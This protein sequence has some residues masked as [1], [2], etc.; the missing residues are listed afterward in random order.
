MPRARTGLARPNGSQFRTR[1]RRWAGRATLNVAAG[2]RG[3]RRG[4]AS[5]D[6]DLYALTLGPRPSLRRG[7]QPRVNRRCV[8]KWEGSPALPRPTPPHQQHHLPRPSGWVPA[9]PSNVPSSHRD[10]GR[11]TTAPRAKVRHMRM[12]GSQVAPQANPAPSMT[13]T[14]FPTPPQFRQI[15]APPPTPN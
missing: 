13:R 7:G 10:V 15:G 9:Q 8:P 4:E 12:H 5:L 14:A 1:G 3:L 11:H 2:L 6:I